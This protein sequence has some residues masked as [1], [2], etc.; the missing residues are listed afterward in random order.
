M[1][2]ARWRRGLSRD[3]IFNHEIHELRESLTGK[4]SDV[5]VRQVRVFVAYKPSIRFNTD[6]ISDILSAGNDDKRRSIFALSTPAMPNTFTTDSCLSH[7]GFGKRIS[8]SPPR[9]SVV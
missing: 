5:S 8:H 4:F 3:R 2:R 9:I 6:S 7:A 1:S